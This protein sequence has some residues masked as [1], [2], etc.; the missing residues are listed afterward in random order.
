MKTITCG[1]ET[2]NRFSTAVKAPLAQI[3]AEEIGKY[4]PPDSPFEMA[5]EMD[6]GKLRYFLR[7][8]ESREAKASRFSAITSERHLKIGRL[9]N[10]VF[11]A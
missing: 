8:K 1:Q 5:A 7:P 11:C 4:L 6:D 3:T 9:M 10:Q 2:A